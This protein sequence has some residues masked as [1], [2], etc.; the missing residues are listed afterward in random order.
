M[1]PILWYS[2]VVPVFL[3]KPCQ[4]HVNKANRERICLQYLKFH[5]IKMNVDIFERSGVKNKLVHITNEFL[6]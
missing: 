5:Q 4:R 3:I 6:F 1:V 2:S